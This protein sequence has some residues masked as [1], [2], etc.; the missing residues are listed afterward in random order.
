MVSSLKKVTDCAGTQIVKFQCYSGTVL[1]WPP[2][3]KGNLAGIMGRLDYFFRGTK[4]WSVITRWSW[5]GGGGGVVEHFIFVCVGIWILTCAHFPLGPTAKFL[6]NNTINC[7]VSPLQCMHPFLG[8]RLP[9]E[10]MTTTSISMTQK[11][12]VIYLTFQLLLRYRELW[13]HPNPQLVK[14]CHQSVHTLVHEPT[15]SAVMA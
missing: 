4:K 3:G 12:F 11:V 10:N 9:L 6:G 5:G 1:I 2:L 13:H 8:Y 7:F 14:Q 15:C